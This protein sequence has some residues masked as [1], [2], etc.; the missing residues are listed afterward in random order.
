MY[1]SKKNSGKKGETKAIILSQRIQEL[2]DINPEI[3][4][5][6]KEWFLKSQEKVSGNMG[7]LTLI[8]NAIRTDIMIVTS[9]HPLDY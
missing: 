9:N 6:G 4:F 8:P 7:R 5:S 3:Y 2:T 1:I